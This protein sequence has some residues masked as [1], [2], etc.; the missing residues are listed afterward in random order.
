MNLV[1]GHAHG[2]GLERDLG[3]GQALAASEVV[4]ESMMG[5]G[6]DAARTS[7]SW[8]E[9]EMGEAFWKHVTMVPRRDR[10][11]FLLPMESERTLPSGM[12]SSVPASSQSLVA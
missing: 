7:P 4:L 8:M 1:P 12:S 3:R 2:V 11:T 6:D 9:P 5:T 10:S